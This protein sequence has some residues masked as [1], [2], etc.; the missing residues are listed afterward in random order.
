[1]PKDAKI[2]TG[3]VTIAKGQTSQMLRLFIQPDTPPRTYKLDLNAEAE[4]P[5]HRNP[6]KVVRLEAA[7]AQLIEQEKELKSLADQ[8]TAQ[9]N[10]VAAKLTQ[11]TEQLQQAQNAVTANEQK[12]AEATK[13]AESATAALDAATKNLAALEAEAQKATAA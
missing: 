8:A 7:K 2:Q 1:L 12:L 6:G 5:Y 4:I 3:D 11:A 13:A 9:A 10:A